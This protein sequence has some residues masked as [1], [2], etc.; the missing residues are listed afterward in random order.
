MYTLYTVFLHQMFSEDFKVFI[1]RS[2]KKSKI[3]ITALNSLSPFPP[4]KKKKN[5]KFFFVTV[6]FVLY[7]NDNQL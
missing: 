4:K 1:L 7:V 5:S 6:P 2:N 3:R